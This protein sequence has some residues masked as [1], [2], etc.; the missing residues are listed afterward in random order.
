MVT[1]RVPSEDASRYGLVKSNRQG[2]VTDF[3]YKPENPQS[4]MATTEVFVYKA[5]V[6]LQTLDELAAASPLKDFGH[7]L[8]PRLVKNGRAYDF[9]FESY[10]RDVGTVE[11]Y[12]QAHMDLLE[13]TPSLTLDDPNWPILSYGTQRIPARVHASARVENSLISSGCVVRGRVVNS[14]LSP[15]VVVEEG[16][17]V[18]DSILLHHVRIEQDA[19]V[20]R[21]IA[22]EYSIVGQKACVS[23]QSKKPASSENITLL[24]RGARVAPNSTVKAGARLEP[25]ATT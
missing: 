7:E 17:V 19:H 25:N 24:G 22:D 5:P 15:G 13:D 23:A 9:R 6:L 3:K 8:L 4:D 12:W 1:T 11:S 18:R 14:V 20:H 16:A 10:W 21:T 2:R